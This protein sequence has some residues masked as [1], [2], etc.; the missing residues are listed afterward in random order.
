MLT[1]S[2][3]VVRTARQRPPGG[4]SDTWANDMLRPMLFQKSLQR[5]KF[6][7]GAIAIGAAQSQSPAPP[8]FQNCVPCHG[9]KHRPSIAARLLTLDYEELSQ[10]VRGGKPQIGMPAFT[11]NDAEMRDLI[12]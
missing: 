12:R 9:G 7:Y 1:Q 8:Q 10:I 11:F 2:R 4:C 5:L 3:Y 6:L